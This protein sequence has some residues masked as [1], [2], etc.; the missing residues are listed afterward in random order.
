MGIH[1]FYYK[2]ENNEVDF[3]KRKRK[4]PQRVAL[5]QRRVLGQD[6]DS[7]AQRWTGPRSAR[8]CE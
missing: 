1:Y 5:L 7:A 2:G 6:L 8:A 4:I 3:F